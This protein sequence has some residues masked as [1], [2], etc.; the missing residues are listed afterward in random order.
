MRCTDAQT[1][2]LAQPEIAEFSAADTHRIF[3]HSF[4]YP[5]QFAGRL[6]DDLQHFGGCGL[7]LQRFGEIVGALAQFV[8]Q[9][10]VLNGDNGLIGE[11]L[12]Q[13]D[14]LVSEWLHFRARQSQN[15]D[16]GAFAQHWNAEH[17][18]EAAQ[19]LGLGPNMISVDTHV[20][21]MNGPTFQ[22][23]YSRGR[24]TFR[25]YR[26]CPHVFDKLRRVPID[27]CK[28]ELSTDLPGNGGFVGSAKSRG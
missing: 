22:Q 7:L 24:A 12:D 3:Q 9:S 6:A 16:G 19:P 20:R 2:S 1:S 5:L 18:A 21:D 28:K 8:K 17:G 13:L 25:L 4:K 14:L 10:R 27:L 23:R 15:A 26:D 11:I